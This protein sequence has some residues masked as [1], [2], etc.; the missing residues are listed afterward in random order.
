[1]EI[2]KGGKLPQ[3]QNVEDW[4]VIIDACPRPALVV[5]PEREILLAN[6][7]FE[8]LLGHDKKALRGLFL[9]EIFEDSPQAQ[10]LPIKAVFKDGDIQ[11][12]F[13]PWMGNHWW[14]DLI[15]LKDRSG[16]VRS[17]LVSFTNLEKIFENL[18]SKDYFLDVVLNCK[19]HGLSAA[20][21]KDKFEALN[22]FAKG[23]VHDLKNLITVVE[24]NLALA[25]RSKDP[26]VKED[27]LRKAS[28]AI[29]KVKEFAENILAHTHISPSQASSDLAKVIEELTDLIFADSQIE[30]VLEL[31]ANLWRVRMDQIRLTQLL[32]NI[33]L[34]A[35][36][37][38]EGQGLIVIRAENFKGQVSNF[39]KEKGA[40]VRLTISDNGPGIPPSHLKRI[41][42]PYFS[43]KKGGHGL[44]LAIVYSIV[45]AYNGHL[46]VFSR[47]GRGTSFVLYLPADPAT[48][49]KNIET[50]SASL[51]LLVNPKPK[52]LVVDDEEELRE[53]YEDL[54]AFLGC[55]VKTAASAEE[56][57]EI[58]K[59]ELYQG[60]PFKLV[61][62]DLWLPD[63][64]G[65]DLLEKLKALDSELKII[66]ASGHH[67]Q[68]LREK[69]LEKGAF[70]FLKKPFD[71][72][73]LERLIK[74]ASAE[75]P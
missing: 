71:L 62:L 69:L 50:K 47:E 45:K 19:C 38:L 37:A 26:A 4:Q 54:L 29:D 68:Q 15:P 27:F 13:I 43:T 63:M 66:V 59:K 32:Q 72:E 17:L 73:E 22:L 55:E 25:E 3:L 18:C 58:F 61:I 20:T 12:I 41:F 9:S 75:A 57:L 6:K 56:A 1:M 44:G 14:V 5:S 64:R 42:D 67:D 46:E 2:S 7:A 52:V 70:A 48:E 31:P 51:C 74:G 40:Y 33:L 60:D 39:L 24:G 16:K 65:E 34:N 10:P 49:T 28:K 23:V 36:E 35:K 53:L 21:L 8:T 30:C 11:R